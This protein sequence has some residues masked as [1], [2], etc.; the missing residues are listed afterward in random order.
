MLPIIK[1]KKIIYIYIYYVWPIPLATKSVT[2]NQI[3][4][5]VYTSMTNPVTYGKR[6][7][8]YKYDTKNNKDK[9]DVKYDQLCY[10]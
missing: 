10:I 2:K 4:K 9:L 7:Y 6:I 3:K 8:Y 1:Y 5:K